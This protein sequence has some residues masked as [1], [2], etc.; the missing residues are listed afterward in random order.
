MRGE[1]LLAALLAVALTA[2]AGAWGTSATASD[3]QRRLYTWSV[4]AL[5]IVSAYVWAF[6]VGVP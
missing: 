5:T 1:W 2:I 4:V 3:S 6:A